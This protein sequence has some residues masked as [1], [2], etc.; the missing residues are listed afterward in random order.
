MK[1][2][3]I[4]EF[5]QETNTFNPIINAVERFNAGDVFE[6]EARYKKIL[7]QKLA[8]AGAVDVFTQAQME[9]IPSVFMHSGSGGRVADEAY[10]LVC[11][12]LEHYINNSGEFDAVYA[13]LHG[14]T[15]TESR[16]D[17][18]GDLLEFI[19]NL[20]GDKP[21]S[22]SCDMHAKITQKMMDNANIICGYQTY[23]HSDH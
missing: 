16:D 17:A 14:A 15:C 10:E 19:R 13:A 8:V 5:H 23:P 4:C 12:R 2:I 9:V 7:A 6:G 3:L 1:R 11:S 22:A 21:I 20:V 18:C